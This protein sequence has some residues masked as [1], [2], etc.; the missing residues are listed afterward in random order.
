MLGS[1]IIE[2]KLTE[3]INE[4]ANYKLS[5]IGVFSKNRYEWMVVDIANCMYRNTLVPI[6]DTLGPASISYVL[7]HSGIKTCFCE[8]KSLDTL[9]NTENLGQLKILISFDAITEE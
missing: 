4:Y 2:L 7:N 3:E 1:G 9:L 8:K 5:L 6:Y